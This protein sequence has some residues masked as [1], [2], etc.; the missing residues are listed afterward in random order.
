M[1]KAAPISLSPYNNTSC[2]DVDSLFIIFVTD[3]FVGV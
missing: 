1:F 2:A 3:L